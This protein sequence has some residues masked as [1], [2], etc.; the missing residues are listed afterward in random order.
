[1]PSIVWKGQLTFGLVSIPVKLYRAARR[2]RVRMH[3]VHR[4][5][6]AGEP[7]DEREMS[8]SE[9]PLKSVERAPQC[10]AAFPPEPEAE[11]ERAPEPLPPIS[12]VHQAL[13]TPNEQPSREPIC[14]GAMKSSRTGMSPSTLEN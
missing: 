6:M 9:V 1:M 7:A 13:V 14:F 10:L 12:R 4:P 11:R 8:P 2:E 5:G 3:Y